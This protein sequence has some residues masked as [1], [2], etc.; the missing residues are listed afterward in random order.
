MKKHDE[1]C[2]NIEQSIRP[3]EYMGGP[4]SEAFFKR[5]KDS[6]ILCQYH[7][8]REENRRSIERR[9]IIEKL[10]ESFKQVSLDKCEYNYP[11]YF[12]ES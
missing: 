4:V 3:Y 5:R 2:S 1:K 9:L 6:Q 7:K 8:F 11:C 10:F 12:F